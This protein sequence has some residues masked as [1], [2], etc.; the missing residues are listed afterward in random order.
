MAEITLKHIS[1]TYD[2]GTRALRDIN[3]TVRDQDFLVLLG[4]SGCGKST[5]L[6]LIAGL[7]KPTEGEI[8]FDGKVVNDLEP[9]KRNVSHGVPELCTLSPYECL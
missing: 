3:L 5:M 8:L 6:R 4:P 9:M 2:N 1:K 7:E